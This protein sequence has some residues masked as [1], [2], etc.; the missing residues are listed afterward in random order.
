VTIA[1]PVNSKKDM[2]RDLLLIFTDSVIVKFTTGSEVKTVK[3]RWCNVC[4]CV[5]K[6]IESGTTHRNLVLGVMQ[7]LSRNMAR[8][9]HFSPV[10]TL[11]AVIIYGNTT[12]CTRNDVKRQTYRNIIG[13]YL[14]QSGRRWKR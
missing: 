11:P 7:N 2:S 8:S 6:E 10:A 4:K 9:R 5:N 1:E 13:R 12:T 14:A 3:G